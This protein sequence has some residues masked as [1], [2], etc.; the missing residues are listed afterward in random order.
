RYP[1]S[2]ASQAATNA[3]GGFDH[4]ELPLQRGG[5]GELDSAHLAAIHAA[6]SRAFARELALV[7][8][9]RWGEIAPRRSA[10][11]LEQRIRALASQDEHAKDA[12]LAQKEVGEP[13]EPWYP[14]L[15]D[16]ADAYGTGGMHC[17]G[18]EAGG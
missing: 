14:T 10:L 16:S 5:T 6:D 17:P 1:G 13:F 8:A 2:K 12:A 3:A 15:R 4:P 9:Q 11:D 7:E 18:V